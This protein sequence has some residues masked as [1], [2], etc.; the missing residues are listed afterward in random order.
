MNTYPL[1]FLVTGLLLIGTSPGWS[2]PAPPYHGS[3][4]TDGWQRRSPAPPTSYERNADLLQGQ[5]IAIGREVNELSVA[6][7]PAYVRAQERLHTYLQELN[8]TLPDYG[9]EAVYQRV[10]VRFIQLEDSLRLALSQARRLAFEQTDLLP[11]IDTLVGRQ[12]LLCR[13]AL[14]FFR[15]D[16]RAHIRAVIPESQPVLI[17]GERG[18]YYRVRFNQYTGYCG[19]RQLTQLL[20]R[21]P[22]H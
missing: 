22:A 19:K 18:P 1:R 15:P 12:A 7:P 10:R 16:H 5:L 4:W 8:A 17:V 13:Y 11:S 2:Q 3:F 6:D 20:P 9:D 21:S 14:L